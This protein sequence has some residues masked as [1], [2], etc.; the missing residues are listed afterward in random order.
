MFNFK[1][2][3]LN[4][5]LAATVAI[6]VAAASLFTSA[7]SA[8]AAALT[9]EF[10]FDG[11]TTINPSSSSLVTL[12]S[13]GL[14]FTPQP[15]TPVSISTSSPTLG[16]SFTAFNSA[17]IK[18]F[19]F[20]NNTEQLLLDFGNLSLFGSPSPGVIVNPLTDTSS[21]TDGKDTFTL[22][23]SKYKLSQD[24]ANVNIG[25]EL[26]GFFTSA[27]GE[28]TKGAGNLTFQKNNTTVEQATEILKNGSLANLAFSGG[29]FTTTVP[30]PTTM[31]GLGLV[32]AG[33]LVSRR[34]KAQA[35]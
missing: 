14:T 24:G 5:T 27:T 21:I 10:D 28:K 23:S 11:G 35:S 1:S 19:S 22:T 15:L 18:N 16:G 30:E 8:Q 34:R 17:S 31:L 33:M 25:V 32:G 4:A 2:Q 26:W 6:P 29:A 12:T 13:N 20:S 7:S 3:V 9:G